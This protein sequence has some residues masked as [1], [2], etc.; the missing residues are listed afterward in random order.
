MQP[1]RNLALA[2]FLLPSATG[3]LAQSFPPPLPPP[4]AAPPSCPLQT[5]AVVSC[6]NGVSG[7]A[8]VESALGLTAPL[9]RPVRAGSACLSYPVPCATLAQ[10]LG[11]PGAS[12]PA[13]AGAVT[14]HTAVPLGAGCGEALRRLTAAAAVVSSSASFTLCAGAS[15]CTASAQAAA[16]PPPPPPACVNVS[17]ATIPPPPPY[18]AG[19]PSSTMCFEGVTGPSQLVPQNASNY[20]AMGA[21]VNALWHARPMCLRYQTTCVDEE[22]GYA[23]LLVTTTAAAAGGATPL[24]LPLPLPALQAQQAAPRCAAAAAEW[25]SAAPVA[26]RYLSVGFADDTAAPCSSVVAALLPQYTGVQGCSSPASKFCWASTP[27]RGSDAALPNVVPPGT[28]A[29][30]AAPGPYWWPHTGCAWSME[31]Y[32]ARRLR[33]LI[34]TGTGCP[35]CPPLNEGDKQSG[36]TPTGRLLLRGR[37]VVVGLLATRAVPACGAIAS[38]LAAAATPSGTAG[39]RCF[40][41]L[42]LLLPLV[43]TIICCSV[44][45]IYSVARSRQ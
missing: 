17:S 45:G 26:Y 11:A 22:P 32:G 5:T 31:S 16:L 18:G 27:V 2:C 6:L 1:A 3:A 15:D 38:T 43:L 41:A 39:G 40:R 21:G 33:R 36:A 14:V 34:G 30:G 44:L 7:G 13:G 29:K 12:C 42:L 19:G 20:T 23:S 35:C 37:R 4:A 28:E 9:S 8:A 25:G 24:L 10:A